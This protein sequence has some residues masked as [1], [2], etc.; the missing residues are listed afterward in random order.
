MRSLLVA[1][2]VVLAACSVSRPTAEDPGDRIYAQLCANCHGANLEGVIGPSLGPG[3][4]AAAQPDEFLRFAIV[5]GR[6]RMPSFR[7]VL[8]DEQVDALIFFIREVQ[9]G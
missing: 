1:L 6:G 8:D 7:A 3:S 2:V 5:N 9:R 4:N